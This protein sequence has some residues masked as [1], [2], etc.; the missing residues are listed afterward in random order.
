MTEIAAAFARLCVETIYRL[1]SKKAIYAAAFA[2]L[3]VETLY[4]L[5]IIYDPLQPPSRGCVLKHC[6]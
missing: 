5:P 4:L 3:C 6:A 1:N 2:R